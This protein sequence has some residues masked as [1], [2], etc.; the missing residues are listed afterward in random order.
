MHLAGALGHRSI[1]STDMGGTTFLVGP[2]LDGKPVTATSTMLHQHSFGGAGPVHG[3]SNSAD[4]GTAEVVI[5]LGSTTAVFS[6]YGL[7]APNI[8]LSAEASDPANR[9][10][11]KASEASIRQTRRHPESAA[12]RAT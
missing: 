6:S 1:I 10:A 5:P 2:A 4:I 9:V 7:A 11:R 3:A 12:L 8:V